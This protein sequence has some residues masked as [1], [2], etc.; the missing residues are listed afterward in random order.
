M[1][2]TSAQPFDLGLRDAAP[3]VVREARIES[4]ASLC[5][6][7]IAKAKARQKAGK[8]L[9]VAGFVITIVA[10]VL[11]CAACFAGGLS[12]PMEDILLHNAVPF[13]RG[14][15]AVLGLG[16]LVWLVG[17]MM[18]LRGAMEEGPEASEPSATPDA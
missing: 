18:F 3:P 10:T 1:E 4:S 8:R 11:Y 9:I 6:E 14:M 17:S 5:A 12:V 2:T 7:R 16:T 13:A 15:L